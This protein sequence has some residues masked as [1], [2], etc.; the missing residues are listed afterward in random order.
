MNVQRVKELTR[1]SAI[2]LT[3]L[4]FAIITWLPRLL[5]P[6]IT[7]D[8][9]FEITAQQILCQ[10]EPITGWPI[11][12]NSIGTAMGTFAPTLPSYLVTRGSCWLASLLHINGYQAFILL[13]ISLTVLITLAA[14]IASGVSLIAS[15]MISYGLATAPCS[16]SRLEH[17]QLS[18]LWPIMPCIATCS[19]LLTRDSHPIKRG[20]WLYA[21]GVSGLLIGLFSFTAQEYYAVLSIVCIFAC[22]CIGTANSADAF[23][24]G[25]ADITYPLAESHE[26]RKRWPYSRFAAGYI[27]AMLM[28][29]SSKQFLW[30]IPIWAHEATQRWPVEQFLYGFWPLNIFTSP[31]INNHLRESFVRA[32]LQVTETPFNSSSGV[33]VIIGLTITLA[34]W[35]RLK[36]GNITRLSRDEALIQAFGGVLITT[37]IIACTVATPGGLGTLFAVVISPQLR[38]LNRITPYFYCAALTVCAIKLEQILIMAADDRK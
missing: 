27:C 5:D 6:A 34:N 1:R 9:L 18:Q 31:L 17:V 24:H 19:I 13:G 12:D 23:K 10:G 29:L 11:N 21:P 8:Q 33:A 3:V 26:K 36:R 28:H 4:A 32:Q 7:G 35:I 37:I 22:Y 25:T 30:N 38:A 15:L 14:S 2:T 16:F 20:H